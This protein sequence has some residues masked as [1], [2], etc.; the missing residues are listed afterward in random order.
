LESIT[1]FN[2]PNFRPEPEYVR[3]MQGYGILPENQRSTDPIDVYETDRRYWQSL[4][5][6]PR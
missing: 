5:Y 2:Q 6:R 4:W 3:E 1:R